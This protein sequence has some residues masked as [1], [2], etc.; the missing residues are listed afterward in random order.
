MVCCL[1]ETT[2][3]MR[4]SH[5]LYFEGGEKKKPDGKSEAVNEM[6][7]DLFECAGNS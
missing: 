2:D 4:S 1:T 6:T 3:S 5:V 7:L